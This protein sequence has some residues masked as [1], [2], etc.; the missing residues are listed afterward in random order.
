MKALI[1]E[2]NYVWGTG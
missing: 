1:I 2:T